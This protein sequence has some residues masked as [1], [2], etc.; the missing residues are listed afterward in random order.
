MPEKLVPIKLGDTKVIGEKEY[1][2]DDRGVLMMQV[3]VPEFREYNL[4]ALQKDKARLEAE[5]AE[6]DSLITKYSALLAA[7]VAPAP[8]PV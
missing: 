3:A 8:E 4:V 1:E 2:L 5:L 6:V 7:K